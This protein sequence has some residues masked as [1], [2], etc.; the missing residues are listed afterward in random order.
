M[1][2]LSGVQP[3]GSLHLGNYFGA[4]KQHIELQHEH[5]C[6]FFIANYHTLT[7]VQDPARLRQLTLDVALDY[8]A[9]GLDPSKAALFRQSDIP[10]VTELAWI[11][12]AVTGKGLLDRAT[13]YKDKVERGITPSVGLYFYPVLMAADILIYRSNLVPVGKDQ[14][15]HIEMTQDMA[16]Y[17]NNTYREV[18][19][20]PEARLNE[21]A[22]VPGL[23]GQKM[24]KSYG[25]Y[26]EIFLD[27]RS[28]QKKIMSIKSDS[29]PVEAPK[30]PDAS[31]AFALLKLMAAK[32]E[33]QEW[34]RRLRAGGV[35]YGELKKRLAE[36]YEGY[37]GLRRDRRAELARRPDEIEDVLRS[38]ATRARAVAEQVMHDVREACGIVRGR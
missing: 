21:A 38:G 26:I 19:V 36:L 23:D 22:I 32:E 25:N 2:V 18:F 17:F 3:S 10:E 31:I 4:M 28:A 6:F 9:M 37:F 1:R 34:D 13:S 8:L 33:T 15:Q 11:L 16:G 12:A 29:T 20:R 35:G 24:S 27:S 5:E 30:D 7:T 14:V